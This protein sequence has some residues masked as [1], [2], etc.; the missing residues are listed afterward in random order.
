MRHIQ[1]FDFIFVIFT[2]DAVYLLAVSILLVFKFLYEIGSYKGLLATLILCYVSYSQS[3]FQI[4]TLCD[5]RSICPSR[6][7]LP[8][9]GPSSRCRSLHQLTDS[10]GL[11][12]L[13][14]ILV[15]RVG[16][17]ISRSEHFVLW[18]NE[19]RRSCLSPLACVAELRFG[20]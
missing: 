5:P 11:E 10:S 17:S 6:C 20:Q 18:K 12:N 2:W 13:A 4:S 3:T 16:L 8:A 19:A 14:I 1:L 15:P 7:G 9:D